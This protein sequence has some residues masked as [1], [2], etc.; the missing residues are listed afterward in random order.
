MPVLVL[1]IAK[2]LVLVD[3]VLERFVSVQ[4]MVA[5]GTCNVAWVG[6]G[7]VLPCGDQLVGYLQGA[8]LAGAGLLVNILA[9]L[10]VNLAA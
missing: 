10:G 6:M 9:G 2:V 5:D 1:I 4:S 8:L 7:Q 3:A